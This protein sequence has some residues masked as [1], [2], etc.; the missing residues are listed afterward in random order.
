MLF[1]RTD[2]LADLVTRSVGLRSTWMLSG[3]RGCS[4][5]LVDALWRIISREDSLLDD[6]VHRYP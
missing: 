4:L 5:E 1:G 6:V 2:A 3:A